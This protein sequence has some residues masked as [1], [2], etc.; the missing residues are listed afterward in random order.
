MDK[1]TYYGN[2]HNNN[3]NKRVY[4]K[5]RLSIVVKDYLSGIQLFTKHLTYITPE[6][7][8]ISA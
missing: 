4:S 7:Y 8:K 2:C 3:N 6:L 1:L 5:V